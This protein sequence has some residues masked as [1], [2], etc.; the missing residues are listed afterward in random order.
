MKIQEECFSAGRFS[1]DRVGFLRY[2]RM[3]VFKKAIAA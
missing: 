1:A 2:H 3:F